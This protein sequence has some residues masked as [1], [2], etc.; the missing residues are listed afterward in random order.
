[1]RSIKQWALPLFLL[2][3]CSG[4]GFAQSINSGDVRGTVT[5][6]T[7]AVIP[8]VKVTVQNLN[9]GVTKVFT[10]NGVGIY[11]T[12][13]ILPGSYKVTFEAAGFH[14][15]VRGPI[16]LEV[17]FTTVNAALKIGDTSEQVVVNTDVPLLTTESGDQSTTM[18]A[19]AM[20]Q[21]PQIG[22]DWTQFVL[23]LPGGHQRQ[24]AVQQRVVGRRLDDTGTEPER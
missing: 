21:I 16:T 6:E 19:K 15:L 2:V 18:D 9:T 23:L 22:Q 12:N 4:L 17:G 8:G 10:S 11:D 3:F 24:P 7:G 14:T 13:S 1:M 5:D 20:S